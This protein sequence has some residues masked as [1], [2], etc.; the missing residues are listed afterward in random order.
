MFFALAALAQRDCAN[1]RSMLTVT[2]STL[3]AS[4][5]SFST[6]SWVCASHT[7]VSSEGTTLMMRTLPLASAML[8]GA[9]PAPVSVAA[10]IGSPTLIAFP[11]NGSGL[12]LNV[13]ACPSPGCTLPLETAICMSSATANEAAASSPTANTES[14]DTNRID[15]LQGLSFIACAAAAHKDE[16]LTHRDAR[17]DRDGGQR[18]DAL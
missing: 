14:E 9:R 5:G 11:L 7:G 1:G 18:R 16:C 17:R 15:F 2:S 13:T 10:G 3:A 6:S 4:A 8:T 12:P